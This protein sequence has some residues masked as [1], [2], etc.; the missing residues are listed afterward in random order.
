MTKSEQVQ[1]FLTAKGPFET[2]AL[3]H[4]AFE[5]ESGLTMHYSQFRTIYIKPTA[6]PV[7]KIESISTMLAKATAQTFAREI[8]K[9][10]KAPE[11]NIKT[12]IEAPRHGTKSL[13][14]AEGNGWTRSKGK[15]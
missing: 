15:S 4:K 10:S 14:A 12:I 5:K 13:V 2:C 3:A 6:A 9:Y 7:Q 1:V 11:H 8:K